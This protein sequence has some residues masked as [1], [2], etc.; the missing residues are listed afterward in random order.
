MKI[1]SDYYTIWQIAAPIMLGS[2]ANAVINFTDVAFVARIGEPQLAASALGG[3]FY[4]I[5]VMI[6]FGFGTGIQILIARR[7]GEGKN[8]EINKVFD[9]GLLLTVGI[10]AFMILILYAFLPRMV[11]L[12]VSDKL[13]AKYC[14]DYLLTRS[15]SLVFMMVLTALRSF[16][17][18]I[19]YTRI[20]SYS[21][22]LMMSL[23]IIFNYMFTLGH[24]GAPEMGVAGSGLASSLSEMIAAFYAI[25]YTFWHKEFKAY[26]LFKFKTISFHQMKQITLLSLPIVFQH[27]I[28][29]VAWFIFFV[30]IGRLGAHELAISNVLRSIYMV[31]MTPIWG[32][33]QAANTMVSNLIGQKKSEEV[34]GLIKRITL[35]SLIVGVVTVLLIVVYPNW[36]F[37][38]TTSDVSLINGALVNFPIICISTIIFSVGMIQLSALSGTGSTNIAMNLEIVNISIYLIY[39]FICSFILKSTATAMWMVEIV[40]WLLMGIFCFGYLYSGKWKFNMNQIAYGH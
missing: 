16:Y 1:K 24:W 15:W 25:V 7:N 6:G 26:G 28:S 12:F 10:A 36:L 37:H 22:F 34:M 29:M 21:T 39:I 4:F 11:P 19:A 17:T 13:V 33:S 5:G 38:L 30:L 27:L 8:R 20:I 2:L 18:G 31:L 35:M 3:L 40:Y 14:C 9:N 23:N 32:F